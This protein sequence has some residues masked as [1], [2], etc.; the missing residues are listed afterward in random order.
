M[1]TLMIN[2]KDLVELIHDEKDERMYKA[3]RLIQRTWKKWLDI[4][5]F[6]YYKE[7]IGFKQ[8]GEPSHLMKYIEPREAELLDAAAGVHI[9]F[10]LGG[11]KFPPSIYYKIFTHR[12]IVD[13]CANSPK[14]YAKIA[15]KPN[16]RK[17][18]QGSV[19]ENTSDWYKRIENNGWRLL[20]I[21]YWKGTDALTTKD[22]NKIQE[23]HHS[24]EQRKWNMI[25]RRKARKI[26]WLKKMYFGENLQVKTETP[27]AIA[28]IQRATEGL[29]KS[30][31]KEGIDQV[32]EWEV[33]EMLKWTNALNYDEYVKLWKEVGT[34]KTSESYQGFLFTQNN[35]SELIPK[36]IQEIMHS[37][38][39]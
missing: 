29:I 34:S 31:E 22:N 10:R 20:S 1:G 7:L 38:I 21:R 32:M 33:D 6:E 4:G 24:P 13:L 36:N 23:F 39:M 27:E 15:T 17:L 11:E 3:A 2:P 19:N 35:V 14:D 26:E 16:P 9:K 8:Y 30:L 18:L 12:P 5:V 37:Q 25:K 28:L